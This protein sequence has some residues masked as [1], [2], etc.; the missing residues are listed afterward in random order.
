MKQGFKKWIILLLLLV[1]P[2]CR[3]DAAEHTL[4]QPELLEQVQ[5]PEHWSASALEFC[6]GNGILKGKGDSLAHEDP[7]TRA[8]TAAILVRLLGAQGLEA[9]LTSY[10]DANPKAWYYA[11][12]ACAVEIGLMRGV[13]EHSLAPNEPVTREQVFVMLSRAFGLYPQDPQLYREFAD[14]GKV[15]NYARNAVSAL[16]ERGILTGYNDGTVRPRAAITRAELAKL[17]YE[18]FTHIVSDPAQLPRQGRVLYN[19]T[20][21]IPADYAL[22]GDLTLGCGIRQDYTLEATSVTGELRLACK[23]GLKA[24]LQQVSANTL[25]A[26]TTTTLASDSPLTTVFAGGAGSLLSLQ[27]QRLYAAADCTVEGDQGFL[28]CLGDRTTVTLNGNTPVVEIYGANVTVQ[29]SGLAETVDVYA[30]GSTV[31]LAHKQQRDYS[32][33]YDYENALSTVKTVYIWDTVV[34]DTKLY[35]SF[36]LYGVIRELPKGTKLEHYYLQD[37]AKAAAVITEDGIFGYVPVANIRIPDALELEQRAYSQGTMEGYV[38]GKGYSSSTGYLIWVSLKTQTVNIFTGKK[39]NWKLLSS[40]PCASGKPA[41]PTVRGVY[42]VRY[43]YDQW[44]FDTYKVCYVTGFYEGYAFHSRCYAPDWSKLTDPTIG[45][46]AS[47]GCLRM[48][49]EDCRFIYESI[50]YGTTVVVY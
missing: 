5:I 11:E 7:T 19:G 21:P 27:A 10:T 3:A 12:V 25:S 30:G 40:A 41:T 39:G 6:V 44:N 23:P 42:S 26:A 33:D 35:S 17:L 50:P 32:Y 29:G 16:M 31:T 18:L 22:E 8:E 43:K 45:T 47:H 14:S 48:L 20:L 9:D 38:N 28:A 2:V 13:S 34:K 1:L 36:G 37:G 46:P 24:Q 4:S 15:S 49:D